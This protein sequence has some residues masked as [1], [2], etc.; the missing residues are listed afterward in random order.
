L[1]SVERVENKFVFL[2]RSVC[3]QKEEH[4]WEF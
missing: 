2:L 3:T 4:K 1:W